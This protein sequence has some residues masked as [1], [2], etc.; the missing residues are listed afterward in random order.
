[1]AAIDNIKETV[2]TVL[3]YRLWN[4]YLL[5]F[6][7]ILFLLFFFHYLVGFLSMSYWKQSS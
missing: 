4:I 7:L 5:I 2:Y 6:H 1:V 3:G